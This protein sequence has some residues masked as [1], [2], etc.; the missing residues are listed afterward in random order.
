MQM[1]REILERA[2]E[3]DPD[4]DEFEGWLL[5][6]VIDAPAGGPLRAMAME[7]HADYENVRAVESFGGWLSEGAPTPRF[8]QTTPETKKRRGS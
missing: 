3:A 1:K 7:I 2:I 8:D 6:Q 4:P 5:Q